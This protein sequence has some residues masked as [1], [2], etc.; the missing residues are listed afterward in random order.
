MKPLN[1]CSLFPQYLDNQLFKNVFYV[2]G[3]NRRSA[4]MSQANTHTRTPSSS[5]SCTYSILSLTEAAD[6][7]PVAETWIRVRPA[8]TQSHFESPPFDP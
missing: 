8:S 2:S 1:F 3:R 4:T 5:L 7:C 6:G